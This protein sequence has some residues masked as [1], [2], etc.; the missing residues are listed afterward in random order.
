MK[1]IYTNV[2]VAKR[3]FRNLL[4]GLSL[5]A[6]SRAADAQT[7]CTPTYTYNCSSGDDIKD[8]ILNGAAG[9][10][11]S[12]LNNPCPPA[13]YMD[14]TTSTA[15]NMTATLIMGN[16]YNGNVTTSYTFA[17]ESVKVWIDFNHNGTFETS[18]VVST[19]NAISNTS[20]GAITVAVPLTAMAGVAHMRVR[21][22]YISSASTI[23][24]CNNVSYGECH[25]Y[26]VTLQPP[27]P[28]NNAGVGSL[29]S[30]D[31]TPFCSNSMKE[32][33]VSVINLGSN[34]LTSAN[35]NWSV[36]G[37][38]QPAVTLPSTLTYYMDSMTVVLGNVL[39]PTTAPL[40]IKAWTDMPNG[41]TDSDHS[42]D[43]LS[44]S[45]TAVLQG[46]DVALS[47]R[48]TIICQG[49]VVTF[50]AGHFPNNPIYIWSTG[51]LDSAIQVSDAGTYSV[52]VQNTM[53][54]FDRDTV[55][56]TMHPNP[57]VNSVAVVDNGDNSFTF[58][59]IGAQNITAYKWD[60]GDGSAAVTGSGL[61]PQVIHPYTT[62]GEYTVT[63]TLSNDCGEI[64]STKQ[65]LVGPATGI[66]SRSALQ[67]E[68]RLYPNPGKDHVVINAN[69]GVR[70]TQIDIYNLTGQ[71][72]L[73]TQAGDKQTIDVSSWANGIY[74]V[75]IAT[76]KGRLTK[77]LEVI[78]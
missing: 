11:I 64:V 38:M 36:N 75:V 58:N 68:I 74:H 10:M 57:L 61:P 42:D 21:L 31:G 48:D 44:T 37:V 67:K 63:L 27:A 41:T 25:D 4:L 51:S 7:Y 6:L 78:R 16:T 13:G 20:T 60:F 59:V 30:P 46:V 52:K 15:P 19:L 54:C 45:A 49:N 77:K 53:G 76:D 12:N 47:P 2:P 72:I 29:I 70:I 14:Y 66:D 3:I 62:P 55:V 23:D 8:V 65:V 50:N 34:A 9:T 35:I 1:E 5:T 69:S 24:P 56:V 22:V 32:V 18:E 28:P 26:K 43:T 73:S 17:S 39:F 40:Q 33:S 71:R